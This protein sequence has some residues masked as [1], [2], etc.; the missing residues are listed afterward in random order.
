MF[1]QVK[2]KKGLAITTLVRNINKAMCLFEKGHHSPTAVELE[3]KC[4][5]NVVALADVP[6]PNDLRTKL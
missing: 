6:P 1:N 5:I 3:Y 4:N 2:I